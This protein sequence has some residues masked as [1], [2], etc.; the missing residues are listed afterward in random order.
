M[1]P[2]HISS[3]FHLVIQKKTLNKTKEVHCFQHNLLGELES[4]HSLS[5]GFFHKTFHIRL[6]IAKVCCVF[7]LIALLLFAAVEVYRLTK[8]AIESD[9][10]IFESKI[11]LEQDEKKVITDETRM[12]Y[13]FCI[14]LMVL[15]FGL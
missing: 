15:I 3:M 13:T 8:T 10:S 1:S 14:G 5:F 9:Y 6:Q 11:H 4:G 7:H 12:L 2:L